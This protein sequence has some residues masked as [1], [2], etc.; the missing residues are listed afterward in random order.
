[1][2]QLH[3]AHFGIDM[4]MSIYIQSMFLDGSTKLAYYATEA[5]QEG[6]NEY[7]PYTNLVKWAWYCSL[8][9]VG[10]QDSSHGFLKK[11]KDAKAAITLLE[12]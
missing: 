7:L 11:M 2:L 12:K 4:G 10:Y 1:M 3:Q 5:Y 8:D 9:I 6:T